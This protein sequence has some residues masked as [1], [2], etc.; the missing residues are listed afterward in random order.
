MKPSR[1]TRRHLGLLLTFVVFAHFGVGHR[2]V[3]AWVLCFGA[4]G[5]VAVEPAAHDHRSPA[6]DSLEEARLT[7][8]ATCVLKTGES[9]CTDIP[10]ISEDHGSHKPL[11]EW[12]NPSPGTGI[13]PVA[14]LVIAL[15]PFD[16]LAAASVFF[17]DPPIID[18]RL[19]AHRSVVLLI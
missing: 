8:K 11:I 16:E 12:K 13:L 17:P 3:P 19:P 7:E 5:H 14:P 6:P 2:D 18:S 9:A 4:D 10:V 1:R 15:I